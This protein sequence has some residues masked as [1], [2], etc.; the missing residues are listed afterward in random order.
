ML[1]TRRQVLALA[2]SALGAKLFAAIRPARFNVDRLLDSASGLRAEVYSRKY[3]ASATIMLFSLPLASKSGV[4][5]GYTVIEEAAAGTGRTVAIQFG[6][7]SYPESAR[8]LNRLGFI[9]E[10]IVEDKGSASDCAYLAFMTTSQEKN[11]DQAKRALVSDSSSVAYSA[12]QGFGQ[13]GKF[14]SRVDR[15]R[16]PARYTWRDIPELIGKAR[17]E[18]A[19]DGSE[20]REVNAEGAQ[21]STFLYSVRRA[22]LDPKPKAATQIFFNSKRF[23]LQTW[24]EKDASAGAHFA[25]K[26]L[27]SAG[28]VIRLNALLTEHRT[29]EKTPFRLWYEEGSEKYP[30]LKFEYQARSFLRL[31]FEA[32]G[33]A[34]VPPIHHV[35]NDRENV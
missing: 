26:K 15:L 25:A 20:L 5:T 34:A 21:L 35:L 33:A 13:G 11:L 14:A 8:G 27:A 17:E 22:L 28:S 16:F 10:V 30:P 19:G 24:K 4:G 1:K 2:G 31:S 32:D 12:A 23:E 7:G 18:M 29:G 3:T 9:Q 6:A